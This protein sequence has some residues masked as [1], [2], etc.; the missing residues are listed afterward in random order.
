MTQAP[1]RTG[2]ILA[3]RSR[4]WSIRA[5]GASTGGGQGKSRTVRAVGKRAKLLLLK[6]LAH[7]AAE[8][9]TV[10]VFANLCILATFRTAWRPFP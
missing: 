7:R 6:A 5:G 3:L 8:Q 9:R 4:T 10:Q 1:G 2:P